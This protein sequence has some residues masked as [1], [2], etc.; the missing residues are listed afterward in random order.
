MSNAR[1]KANIPALNFSSTGIDDNATS[2]AITID[3]SENVGI[4]T[5]SPGTLL[6]LASSQPIIRMKDTDNSSYAHIGLTSFAGLEFNADVGN[7]RVATDIKFFV[8]NSEAMRIDSSGNVAIG[9]TSGNKQLTLE[10][11]GS[12]CGIRINNSVTG[13]PTAIGF[14]DNN[15]LTIWNN[16]TNG[17]T[18]FYNQTGSGTERMR[19]DSSG[20]VGIGTS[21]PSQKLDVN[22]QINVSNGITF[23][24]ALTTGTGI[25]SSGT[26]GNL[27]LYSGGVQVVT[28]TSSKVGIGTSSP[29]SKLHIK[30]G[31]PTVENT[32]SLGSETV[33]F[34]YS[35][36]G[37][38]SGQTV[39]LATL[40]SPTTAAFAHAK[41][42]WG[43]IYA[44]NSDN[45]GAVSEVLW[46][47]YRTDGTYAT[48]EATLGSVGDN[49]SAD[50]YWDDNVLKV[51]IPVYNSINAN[52]T[53]T[54][55]KF[56]SITVN[57]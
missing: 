29:V 33:N 17:N 49:I 41:I 5:A 28:V 3:S 53:I 45:G 34:V 15:D 40:S 20:N 21:S 31:E 12:N 11:S 43:S 46:L 32:T 25:A 48:K 47:K 13:R 4:G 37:G 23:S 18:L 52:I 36:L 55:T 39:T 1:D 2:T 35:Q 50:F 19:I 10:S 38:A 27:R 26:N 57:V 6:E 8:D 24:G 51:D 9:T 14:D 22:G 42:D 30:D 56:G 54:Y 44:V 16:S 7:T